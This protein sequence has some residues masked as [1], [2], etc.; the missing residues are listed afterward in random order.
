MTWW[1][2]DILIYILQPSDR[3]HNDLPGVESWVF[4]V[5]SFP[6]LPSR[7][8]RRETRW[9]YNGRNRRCHDDP[10][11]FMSLWEMELHNFIW[12]LSLIFGS[13]IVHQ[14]AKK[15]KG[16]IMRFSFQGNGRLGC[17]WRVDRG[18]GGRLCCCCRDPLPRAKRSK[19]LSGFQ[20]QFIGGKSSGNLW[21]DSWKLQQFDGHLPKQKRWNKWVEGK[22][23][24]YHK[25]HYIN[26]I[27]DNDD[28]NNNNK[29]TL[30]C[31]PINSVGCYIQYSNWL[32]SSLQTK[33]TQKLFNTWI[34]WQ[35]SWKC[36]NICCCPWI[37]LCL[38][39]KM[40]R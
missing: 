15:K 27:K 32:Y 34:Q 14:R 6:I 8:K 26:N 39:S 25:H 4:Y 13:K 21:L 35:I 9:I 1:I 22:G 11:L 33:L 16:L 30:I 18:F 3:W 28:D 29:I 36:R 5:S 40:M 17:W 12:S 20:F 31:Y 23:Y 38:P 19:S 24:M 10:G 37:A 7:T 2:D